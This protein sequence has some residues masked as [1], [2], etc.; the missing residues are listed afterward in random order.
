MGVEFTRSWQLGSQFDR[1]IKVVIFYL[2]RRPL[3]RRV[4]FLTNLG[5]FG[6]VELTHSR[7]L[8]FSI[9][10]L[11]LIQKSVLTRLQVHQY[12]LD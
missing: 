9:E 12:F 5:I 7:R 3:E 4:L 2:S 6:Q 11:N 10:S 1:I 8:K